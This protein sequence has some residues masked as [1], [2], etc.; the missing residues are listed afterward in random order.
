MNIDKILSGN[1]PSGSYSVAA[2]TNRVA[3]GKR[4]G[5]LL[6]TIPTGKAYTRSLYSH[7]H[8]VISE[9]DAAAN[10]IHVICSKYMTILK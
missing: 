1:L 3:A 8:T 9:A 5:A 4:V 2:I 6:K 7:E 10:K